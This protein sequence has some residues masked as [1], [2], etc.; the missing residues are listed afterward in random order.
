[1]S[2][3]V[4]AAEVADNQSRAIGAGLVQCDG[5][6]ADAPKVDPDRYDGLCGPPPD[7]GH[8]G[9]RPPP[10]RPGVV[11]VTGGPLTR[12]DITNPDV[13]TLASNEFRVAAYSKPDGLG[14][15]SFYAF[16]IGR[17]HLLHGQVRAQVFCTTLAQFAANLARDGEIVTAYDPYTASL[18]AELGAP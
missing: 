14:R 18:L 7:G 10:T 15:V 4:S 16:W 12:R 9:R 2:R 11:T 5:C 8:H 13:A 1:M 6:P 3:K 17:D